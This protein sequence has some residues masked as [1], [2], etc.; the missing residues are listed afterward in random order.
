M[1]KAREVIFNKNV[2]LDNNNKA[3]ELFNIMTELEHTSNSYVRK[4]FKQ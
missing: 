2:I 1:N 3:E 4:G